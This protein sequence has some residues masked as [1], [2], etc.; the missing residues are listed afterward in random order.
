[1]DVGVARGMFVSQD[2]KTLQ[3]CTTFVSEPFPVFRCR[4]VDREM[5][6]EIYS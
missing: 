3:H 5:D 4:F 1:M 6:I 2:V